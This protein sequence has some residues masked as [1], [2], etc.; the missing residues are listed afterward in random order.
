[1][2]WIELLLQGTAILFLIPVLVIFVQVLSAYLPRSKKELRQSPP[3]RIAVLVP[4]H[5]EETGIAAT[6][7]SILRQ[8]QAG[9]R[10]LVVA[11]NCSDNTA[12]IA[13]EYGA[14]VIERHH[15]V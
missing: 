15:L 5:N 7:N 12:R 9:D 2:L 3:A 4:V 6:I 14:E 1:M 10:L 11:D 8:L 13:S